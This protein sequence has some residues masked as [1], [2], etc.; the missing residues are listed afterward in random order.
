MAEK[1]CVRLV[2]L[3]CPPVGGVQPFAMLDPSAKKYSD[4]PLD[5][6]CR[7]VQGFCAGLSVMQ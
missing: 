7:T 1:I 5:I 2:K 3:A 4:A 6:V